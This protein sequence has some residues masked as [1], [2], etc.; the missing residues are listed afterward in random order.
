MFERIVVFLCVLIL[1][2]INLTTAACYRKPQ[3]ATG[4][5]SPV[6]ENYQILIDGNPATYIPGQQYNLSLSSTNGLKFISFT[7]LVEAETPS[8]LATSPNAADNVLGR[9]EIIDNAETRFSTLCENMIESSNTNTKNRIDVAWMAPS[10][11]QGGCVLFKAAILQHRNVWFV[12]D[13]F[14]TKRLCPEEIDE[15]NSQTPPVNPCCACDE[16]K[17]EITLERKW[18]RNTHAKDFP[19]EAW[20][21]RLGEVIGASH[22][23]DFRFW[24]YGGRASQGLQELG[25]HGATKTLEN[26]IKQHT[27][28]GYIRTIIK[29]PGIA[30]RP[31]V[32][33]KTLATVR[34]GPNHHVISLV[35]KIDPS[36][37]WILGVSGLELCLANCTWIEQKVLNLYPWDIGTDAG[38][39]YMSPDQSQHPPDVIRRITSTFPSDYRSPFFDETGAPMKPLATLTVKRKRTYERECDFE[40]TGP[41]ECSTH[42]WSSWTECSAKCGAGTQYRT[43]AYK[44]PRVAESFNCKVVLRQNQNCVGTQCGIQQP[45]LPGAECEL[46]NWSQWSECSKK[47]GKGFQTRT[48]DYSNPYAK[49]KCQAGVPVD[50]QQTRSCNG[51]NCGGSIYSSA[52]DS[53]NSDMF[54]QNFEEPEQEQSPYQPTKFERKPFN[55]PQQQRPKWKAPEVEEDLE[56]SYGAPSYNPMNF[57]N[58]NSNFRN[59]VSRPIIP[60]ENEQE[61][62][63][64]VNNIYGNEKLI[65]AK[66]RRPY[67]EEQIENTNI[68]GELEG[69]FGGG[70]K[71]LTNTRKSNLKPNKQYG[72]ETNRPNPR[73][74]DSFSNRAG[75]GNTGNTFTKL[76]D[77]YGF[78]TIEGQG[79]EEVEQADSYCLYKPVGNPDPC[80]KKRLI[81]KNYW[82]YDAEDGDCK[83]FTADNCDENKNKFWSMERC[84][85]ACS[86]VGIKRTQ[87]EEVDVYNNRGGYINRGFETGQ[88]PPYRPRWNY[89]K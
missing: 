35:S 34:V 8:L 38:P 56:T 2:E 14:L 15:I 25:E 65:G 81:V 6:D 62:F 17:Y 69:S 74:E 70:N 9:F 23:L 39:S 73:E 72:L 79:Q 63:V 45:D 88:Q 52:Y 41:L 24:E 64:D 29:A 11:A 71:R 49:E 26:E 12:D 89:R 48:R 83:L 78:K 75:F 67:E 80:N 46:T 53:I 20:R 87:V 55:K 61:E 13:G 57:D 31:N 44:D 66:G 47:C 68:F 50:L 30:Y 60:N 7:L 19:S 82:F 84:L 51:E 27:S 43:R 40:Q 42:P 4:D 77:P 1:S 21:T 58:D 18:M 37:D 36:P 32:I 86:Q 54:N 5:R 76:R 16:A 22:S 59:Q 3:G 10:D 85:E 28:T 33:G